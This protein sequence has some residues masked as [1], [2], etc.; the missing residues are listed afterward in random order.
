MGALLIDYLH[1]VSE[2]ILGMKDIVSLEV[3]LFNEK[4]NILFI[5]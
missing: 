1:K 5:T 3:P 4:A 2:I